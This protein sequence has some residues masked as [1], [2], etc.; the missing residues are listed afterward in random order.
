MYHREVVAPNRQHF[1]QKMTRASETN[2]PIS[3]RLSRS[4]SYKMTTTTTTVTTTSASP[5]VF[6]PKGGFLSGIT[7]RTPSEDSVTQINLRFITEEEFRKERDSKEYRMPQYKPYTSRDSRFI[8]APAHASLSIPTDVTEKTEN[9]HSKIRHCIEEA[10]GWFSRFNGRPLSPDQEEAPRSVLGYESVPP[11]P[12]LKVFHPPPTENAAISTPEWTDLELDVVD[13]LCN[14]K[15]GKKKVTTSDTLRP[16]EIRPTEAILQNQ[17]TLQ[18]K[19]SM[20]KLG[21]FIPPKNSPILNSR[22]RKPASDAWRY[23]GTGPKH[24]T[25]VGPGYHLTPKVS[26]TSP[27]A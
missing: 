15:V 9:S 5:S 4:S 2:I 20:V 26:P 11:P 3:L 23:S 13:L 24:W 22:L 18:R 6:V 16:K 10:N 19:R 14:W 21:D 27:R 17:R 25:Y 12:T 7:I 1:Q 8:G